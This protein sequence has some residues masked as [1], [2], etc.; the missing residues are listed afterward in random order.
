TGPV[1]THLLGIFRGGPL[2]RKCNAV[3]KCRKERESIRDGQVDLLNQLHQK[4]GTWP[5]KW[6]YISKTTCP[7]KGI[8]PFFSPGPA[9]ASGPPIVTE[10]LEVPV[11]HLLPDP[12][13]DR[14]EHLAQRRRRPE[15]EQAGR[16]AHIR[17][18][19]LH[20]IRV[21]RVGL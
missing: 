19:L 13:D 1:F 14:V 2:T 9:E 21:R 15:A 11:L 6:H 7:G 12:G 16:L 4:L 20:V 18:A 8:S 3:E 10:E 5:I 17:N